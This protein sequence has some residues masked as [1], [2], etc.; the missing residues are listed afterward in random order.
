VILT[1][2]HSARPLDQTLALLKENR[3]TLLADVRAVPRSRRNPQYDSG[4]FAVALEQV[5]IGYRH[6]PELGGM[7]KPRPGSVNEGF[8]EDGFR[9]YADFMQTP[10]FEQ[11]LDRLLALTMGQQLVYM[12]AEA[13]PM[14]CHRSLI[15]DALTARGI[16]I[17][18]ILGSGS[19]EAHAYTRFAEVDGARV[20]YPF[21]L[22]G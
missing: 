20:T 13:K 2:G 5:G 9:G 7:R 10:K 6:L 16:E 11:A 21:R 8:K 3:I 19:T 1:L 12:C 17:R 15:S 14:E 22:E 18:H 4:A